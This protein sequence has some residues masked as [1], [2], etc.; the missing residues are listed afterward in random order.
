MKARPAAFAGSWYAGTS[1]K[2]REQIEECFTHKLGPGN[3]PK[4]VKNGP[5]KILGLISPHAG[6]MYSGPIAAH[7]YYQLA[8]DGKP[9][10]IVILSPNHTG[11]G[12]AL[13]IMKEGVW[14]TP[15][16]EVEIDA[17]V[18]EKILQESRVVD[19]DEK[20]HAYEHSIE[21]QLPFL[22]YL[23]G[24]DFRFV[25]VCFLMQDL[26]SSR[27]VGKAVAKALSQEDAVVIASTDMTHYEPHES[28][29]RK[30]GM[31]IEAATKLDEG[32][33]YSTVESYGISTC[34]Y[35]P[36]VA[37]I[38][39]AKKLGGEKGQLLCYQTSGDITGDYSAVVGYASISFI[40]S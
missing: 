5:R 38:A 32:E 37:M 28:A 25:P 12:S 16:G 1:E 17:H 10:V 2:L 29:K 33:Y 11:R 39:A 24:S 22:Q 27:E 36:V 21:L 30:D 15:L 20:A 18:A 23:Y 31:I 4:V 14:R 19:V 26:E 9:N 13:A 35:G 6:Y 3:L 40:K 7:G 34:G 8:A